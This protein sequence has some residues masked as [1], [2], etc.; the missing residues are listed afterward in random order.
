MS[1]VQVCI[2]DDAYFSCM[3]HALT[4]EKEEVMGL[5]L[6]DIE[7]TPRGDVAHITAISVLTRSDKR[8]DRVEIS[9]EQLTAGMA[10]ADKIKEFLKKETRVIG[11]YHSH[12]HITVNPS[13]FDVQTQAMYQMLDQGFIGLI[14]SCFNKDPSNRSGRIQVTA[15]QSLD[16]G[17]VEQKRSVDLIDLNDSPKGDSMDSF[18]ESQSKVSD[19]PRYNCIDVP[20]QLVPSPPVGPNTLEK[21][22]LLQEILFGEEKSAYLHAIKPLPGDK[23]AHP[24][25]QLHSSA[26]YQKALSR[27]LETEALPL[28]FLLKERNKQNIEKVKQLKEEKRKLELQGKN[29]KPKN[30]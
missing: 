24:L 21:L 26:V 14:F 8:K 29:K 18:L 11:W 5:L 12:P 19:I 15:F 17:K 28:L 23:T 6:G 9:P 30:V 22:F 1:L 7:K 3:S 27:L 16:L 2:T 4:T 10:E 13:H 25:V 20:L